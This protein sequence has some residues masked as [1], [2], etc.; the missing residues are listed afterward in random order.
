M[1][2]IAQNYKTGELTVLDVP[3]PVCRPG[4]VL[5]RSLFS[6]ISAGTELMK[7]SEAS[8]SMIGMA[9]A[10]PDQ[11]RKVLD[12]VQQQGLVTTYKKVVNKLDSYTPLGYSL[13]GVVTEAGRGAE[14]F[15]VGQLVACAGSE[16]AL[17][18]EY[19]WVPVNLCAAV[20][21]GVPPEHAA[22][23]TV[24]S[25]AMHG[26]RRAEVQLG[27][28]AAVIGLG[29]I[30]QLVVRLLAAAGVQAIGIDPVP[31]RRLLAE[32]AGA[33][34]CGSPDKLDALLAELARITA[35][36]GA[37]HV[38]MA[39]GGSSNEP[40]EVAVRLARDRA[41]IVDIGKTKLDL[42]W[43]A[44]YEKELDVRFSRSY[45]PGRY[46]TR[47]ELD[48]VDY[49]AGYVRWTEKRNL[50]SFLDL[51]AR[52]ALEVGTLIDGVFPM[53][54]AVRVYE[55]LKTGALRAVGVL[56]EYPAPVEGPFPPATSMLRPGAKPPSAQKHGSAGKRRIEIGFVGAGNYASAMLLPHLAKLGTASLAHVA[57]ARSLSA[58]NAQ[59]KFGFTTAST[60]A[61]SVF[62][63][64]SL[65]AI[66]IVTR[67]ATH[68]GLVC[69]ALET[70]KAVFVEKPLALTRQEADQIAEA[71][72]KTGNDR[73]MVGFNRR[74]APLLRSMK[75]DFGAAACAS[76]TR[77]L[78]N[79]GPLAKDSWYLNDEA[80][81]SRFTGE[82]GHFIDTLSWWADSL[83]EEVY[84]VRG[85]AK[86]DVLATFRFA[87]GT[88]GSVA[89]LTGGNIRYP[90]ETMDAAG[91]GRS[92]RL[93]NFRSAAVWTGRGQGT[94][95]AR[96]GQ[97]KGQ[98]SEVEQFV[99]SVRTGAPMPISLESLLSTTRATVAAAESLLSGRPVRVSG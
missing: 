80:E 76:V 86:A 27:E 47:Y 48:G 42:P 55:D 64:E 57:T 92:A 94:R 26:V 17:H 81:G 98:R 50:E 89:Y 84:A 70:G 33:V 46:D 60:E 88:S 87:N 90:K 82:G 91:G 85:P 93:D 75:E 11:V 18:A 8:M 16:Q 7:V 9:R 66:F 44:Y 51:V 71:V 14:E 10:R 56:L 63:D 41:R 36:R 58:A 1:K 6:L 5:V 72:G 61:E 35:G 15:T 68:A 53:T 24:A 99:E 62:G 40:V 74:F 3:A 96:G 79:A 38:F 95:K 83:A 78:V 29:L 21:P 73:L 37:D 4:G 39:A 20:P 59:R 45:G 28:T 13:C 52:N 77:Y 34:A 97:D 49:P 2:Q 19:N 31:D 65:D 25:I 43:N 30:G 67:H 12:Q 69:R 54:E 23:A 32:K 22:F